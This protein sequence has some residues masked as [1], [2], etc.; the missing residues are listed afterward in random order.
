MIEDNGSGISKEAL[1]FIFDCFYRAD[2]ARNS[3]TGRSGPGLAIVRRIVE[4]HGGKVWAES[5]V[6]E[7]T[8]I[9]FMIKKDQIQKGDPQ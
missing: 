9:C 5:T 1:P 8:R 6:D 7:G 4:D 2:P 3:G